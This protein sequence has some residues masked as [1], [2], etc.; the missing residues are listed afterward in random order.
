MCVLLFPTR[1]S[2]ILLI[3][4]RIQRLLI[5]NVHSSSCVYDVIT[6][7]FILM[8]EIFGREQTVFVWFRTGTD[9][10]LLRKC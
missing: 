10:G 2:E 6:L 8:N 7:K 9:G 1:L 4:R 3:P 5:V